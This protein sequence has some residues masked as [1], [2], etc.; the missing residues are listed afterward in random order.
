M[1][2]SPAPIGVPSTVAEWG[3]AGVVWPPMAS[4]D[5]ALLRRRATL[6]AVATLSIRYRASI[7]A[8]VAVG[9]GVAL[10]C[11]WAGFP[12]SDTD[13]YARAARSSGE[14]VGTWGASDQSWFVYP[15]PL[16][17]VFRALEPLGREVTLVVWLV[18]CSCA[19]AV[20]AGWWALASIPIGFLAIATQVFPLTVP[21][22]ALL[23]GNVQCLLVASVALG[24]RWPA[25]WAVPL[26]TK[27]GPGIGVL[28]F[29]FRREWRKFGI[30]LGVTLSIAAGTFVV[31]PGLWIRWAGFVLENADAPSPIATIGFG[32]LRF[33]VAIALI[34]WGARTNRPWTVPIACGMA[35]FAL[36]EWSFLT[37]WLASLAMLTRPLDSSVRRLKAELTFPDRLVLARR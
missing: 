20:G 2:F 14:Y 33:A 37:I 26:L 35:S 4:L 23:M 13:L 19:L 32:P 17:Y 36:Y 16:L 22:G 12:S 24:L 8:M 28:W 6:L 34:A 18:C 11:L 31:D 3:L 15:P 27:L 29:A 9:I 7:V 25:L 30:A 21:L 10:Y 1:P 5:A